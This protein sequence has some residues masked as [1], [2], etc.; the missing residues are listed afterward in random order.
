[1]K[2]STSPNA[3]CCM[4]QNIWPCTNTR[5]CRDHLLFC[6]V[7][8]AGNASMCHLSMLDLEYEKRLLHKQLDYIARA[9]LS[10][11]AN[12]MPSSFSV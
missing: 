10:Q 11:T 2:D 7:L 9:M 12:V 1:L 8:Q 6:T 5:C 4:H 3:A